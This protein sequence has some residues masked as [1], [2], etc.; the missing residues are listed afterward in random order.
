MIRHLVFTLC[1]SLP[2]LLFC[3]DY[4]IGVFTGASNYQGDLADEVIQFA[5][6]HIAF[7]V[8]LRYN[9]DP[10][11]SFNTHVYLGR[12]S[13][14]DANSGDP[15]RRARG[16][17]FSA[18]LTE[19][20]LNAEWSPFKSPFKR[21]GAFRPTLS[22]F[23]FTGMNLTLSSANPT[24]PANTVPYPFPEAGSKDY[25]ISIPL[26]V[27]LKYKFASNFSANFEIGYRYAFSDYLDGVSIHGNP[28]NNDLYVIGGFSLNFTLGA[29]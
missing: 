28:K 23:L 15:G 20:G 24:A 1:L 25:F 18:P 10:N 13:G 16:Y 29:D 5:E 3:Q 14:N 17:S 21:W 7:G 8:I 9:Q 19:I 12:I 27:G 6:T 4:E 2:T 11:W 26:G 22:P